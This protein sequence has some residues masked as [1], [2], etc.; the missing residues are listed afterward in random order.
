[1]WCWGGWTWVFGYARESLYPLSHIS[2]P[3]HWISSTSNT[4][5]SAAHFTDEELVVTGATST[6]A[7][8]CPEA[9]AGAC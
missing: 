9:E 7:P 8:A 6:R 3:E 5:A 2:I 1:M 4:A